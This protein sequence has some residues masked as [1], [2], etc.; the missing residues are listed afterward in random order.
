MAETTDKQQKSAVRLD[1]KAV[2]EQVRAELKAD[3]AA[4]RGL[5][6]GFQP[7]LV[8]IQVGGRSDSSV[9]IR[10]KD[11]ACKEVGIEFEHVQLDEDV[12]Q[13][14][15][16]AL[17][18]RVNGDPRVHG[19]IV[20]LPVP[21]HLSTRHIVHSIAPEKDV[22]GFHAENIG[23]L[24]KRAT[25]PF[26]HS[27]TPLGCIEL[28]R[29]YGV[30][31]AGKDAVVIGRSDIVGTPMAMMLSNLDATVTLCHSRTRDI[32]QKVRAA[33]VVVAAVGVAGFVKAAWVKPGAVVVDVGMNAVDDA[34]KKAGFR[35]AGDVE[36]AAG[37]RAA[38]MTPVPGG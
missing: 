15:L 5:H 9:Y 18:D 33:D 29:R 35:W 11:K 37:E 1:G 19:I 21:A 4:F 14:E 27:C 36:P 24:S 8:A 7:K 26:F 23:H 31:V 34:S 12:Q 10:Q 2:S 3:V 17:V 6:P 25:E 32:E 38:Y 13:G 28:L 30:D 22:D 16:D 20:Q